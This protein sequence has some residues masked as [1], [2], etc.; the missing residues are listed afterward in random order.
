MINNNLASSSGFLSL[1]NLQS[2][3]Q[4]GLGFKN[5][6][7][8]STAVSCTLKDA[9]LHEIFNNFAEKKRFFY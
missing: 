6:R 3:S 7:T 4:N 9:L 5:I 1:N 8:L 2:N